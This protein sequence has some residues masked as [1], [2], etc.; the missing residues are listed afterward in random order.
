MLILLQERSPLSK[1]KTHEEYLLE[2][3]VKDISYIP[4]EEYKTAIKLIDHK[5][6]NGHIWK[7]SPNKI[8]SGR[9]CPECHNTKTGIRCKKTTEQYYAELPEQ[10]TCLENYDGAHKPIKHKCNQGHE[11]LGRPTNILSGQGCPKCSAK[12]S[13]SVPGNLYYLHITDNNSNISYYK[14]GVTKQTLKLRFKRD[15]NKKFKV[16]LWKPFDKARD[17]YAEEQ[18][19]LK[20]FEEYRVT[21]LSFLKSNGGTELFTWDI[22]QLDNDTE[23]QLEEQLITNQ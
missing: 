4:I 15:S 2:L 17:A 5:C 21:D 12:F 8:L 7:V 1:R 3:K 13:D 14:I 16:L 10:I 20:E 19:I 9:G 6:N 18:N 11:W 22:L 23:A